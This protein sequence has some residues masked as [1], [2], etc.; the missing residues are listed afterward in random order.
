MMTEEDPLVVTMTCFDCDEHVLVTVPGAQT[1]VRGGVHGDK[2]FR[3]T[4]AAECPKCSADMSRAVTIW[5]DGAQ[6]MLQLDPIP[7][8]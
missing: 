4:F 3:T 5:V 7:S 8:P 2:P 6:I 1:A